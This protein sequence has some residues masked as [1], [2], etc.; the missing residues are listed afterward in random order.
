MFMSCD[1]F[2]PNSGKSFAG[3]SI[4]LAHRLVEADQPARRSGRAT[5]L[6]YGW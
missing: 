3:Q 6:S 1:R 5:A 2:K 4:A